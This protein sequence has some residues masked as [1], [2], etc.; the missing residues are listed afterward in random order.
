MFWIK[1]KQADKS[2]RGKLF[3]RTVQPNNTLFGGTAPPNNTLFGG[4]SDFDKE[5]IFLISMN[6][7]W[8]WEINNLSS[9]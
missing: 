6:W 9:F 1:H 5:Y 4:T 3:V 7:S 8:L 2:K